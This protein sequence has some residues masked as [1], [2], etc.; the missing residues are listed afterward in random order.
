[1]VG[2]HVGAFDILVFACGD[3]LVESYGQKASIPNAWT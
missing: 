3:A 1:L 2:Q